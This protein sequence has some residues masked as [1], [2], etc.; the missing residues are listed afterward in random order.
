[1]TEEFPVS[2][3]MNLSTQQAMTRITALS[4]RVKSVANQMSTD[5]SG[6]GETVGSFTDDFTKSDSKIEASS[7]KQTQSLGRVAKGAA[8]VAAISGGMFKKMVDA[9]PGLASAM[10]EINFLF[11]EMF[12][13]LGES[14]APII[15]D[16]VIP[17]VEGLTEWVMDLDDSFKLLISG[18]IG[19]TTMF[20]GASAI[21]SLFGVSLSAIL[22][23][24]ALIIAALVLL[25]LAWE[26]NFGNIQEHTGAVITAL[27]ETFASL[28]ESFT[29]I[30]ETFV[31]IFEENKES[32]AAIGESIKNMF[33]SIFEG[34]A[35]IFIGLFDVIKDT[36][37]G[38]SE[39]FK[40]WAKDNEELIGKFTAAFA[41]FM[42]FLEPVVAWIVDKIGTV[43]VNVFKFLGNHIKN[44]FDGILVAIGWVM[45]GFIWFVD[46][47]TGVDW[48]A[49]GEH[50][51][52]AF[53]G[54]LNG[55][56]VFIN[57]IIEGINW[58]I[59]LIETVINAIPGVEVS[60]GRIAEIPL[61]HSGGVVGMP[62]TGTDEVLTIL[63]RGEGVVDKGT[64]QSSV[65]GP[66]PMRPIMLT[67]NFYGYKQ[68]EA[69]KLGG[70]AE[71]GLDRAFRQQYRGGTL[72]E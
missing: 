36:V 63:Q 25:W 35:N 8:A 27:Q 64:M 1:M 53:V 60:L 10:A 72:S 62:G 16:Y 44:V 65:R 13:V 17:A 67:Q 71:R 5:I 41:K 46:W 11:E 70:I 69:T 59:N 15:E 23:P 48:G 50:I 55:V 26:T 47:I 28:V 31:T 49:F 37:A 24:I 14:L 33:D 18:G 9:S 54:A 2:M 61:M 58:I 40:T 42:K 32:L 4:D 7:Q 66:A 57:S 38:I 43:L 51:E 56:I 12:M 20:S 39:S 6:V 19:L 34:I 3:V 45:K 22:G 52:M 21:L 68:A 30:M 29:E